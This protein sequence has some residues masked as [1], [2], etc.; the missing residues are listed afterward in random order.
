MA[1][2]KFSQLPTIG[3]NIANAAIIPIVQSGDN[4]TVTAEDFATFATAGAPPGATGPTGPTGASG[5]AG[6]A[7][8]TGP[9]GPA[10]IQG[11]T[12]PTGPQGTTGPTGPQGTTGNTGATGPTGASGP[13]G[14]TGPT[15]PSGPQGNLGNTGSTGPTGPTG[16][17]GTG[18]TG[19]TGPQGPTGGP[20]ATGPTGATGPSG[21]SVTGATG[22]T[23]PTG[24]TGATG[25]AGSGS[26]NAISNG[27]TNVTIS[28][29]NGNISMNAGGFEK[30][31]VTNLGSGFLG[32]QA[33]TN[34]QIGDGTN[35]NSYFY[36]YGNAWTC[37][38]GTA[39]DFFAVGP[40]QN[41]KVS[42]AGVLTQNARSNFAG[43]FVISLGSA[44]G[45]SASGN[46]GEIIVTT[47]YIYVCTGLGGT[48]NWKR[49]A[50][51]SY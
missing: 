16:P 6:A 49:V 45:N 20:G 22:P 19:P 9:T 34:M 35:P 2:V 32:I 25:P 29:T 5:P 28:T 15:G 1:D 46:T 18:S 38:N 14:A 30:L 27:T 37:I 8:A 26:G 50:L 23:G 47:S 3:G 24:P 13:N 41:F 11:T 51:S 48:N 42:A 21:S 31:R 10:G 44:P 7:G 39:A 40:S 43:T 12:G 4:Y 33:N 36:T 17:A